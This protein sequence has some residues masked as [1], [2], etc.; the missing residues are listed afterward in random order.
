MTGLDV[1]WAQQQLSDF[2]Y[3][4]DQVD[5]EQT[6]G[7]VIFGT[8]Y[9]GSESQIA[10]QAQVVEQILDRVLPRWRQEAPEPTGTG[11]EKRWS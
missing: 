9:R 5:Y 10:G 6:P 7:L 3:L 8:H 4:T 2:L 11:S 1:A